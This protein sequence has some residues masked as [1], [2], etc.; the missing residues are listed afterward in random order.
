MVMVAPQKEMIELKRRNFQRSWMVKMI[1]THICRGSR[2]LQIQPSGI[3]LDG[4]QSSVLC[5]L[6]EHS[7]CIHAYLKKQLEITIKSRLR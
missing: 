3:E 6:D 2:D 5:C 7:K 1:W 4:H